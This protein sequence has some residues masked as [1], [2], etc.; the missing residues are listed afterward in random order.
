MDDDLDR[1]GGAAADATYA[2]SGALNG[3]QEAQFE[4]VSG[5]EA[6]TVRSADLGEELYRIA[7]PEG[8]PLAPSV[9]DGGD[10]VELSLNPTGRA[11]TASVEVQLNSAVR[12]RVR[13]AG[14]GLSEVVDFGAGGLAELEL[15]AGAS[16][17]DVVVPGPAGTVPIRLGAGA[18]ELI[19]HT[20]VGVPTQVRL[21]AGA[22]SVTVDGRTRTGLAA[23]TLLT[24][25]GWAE[26]TDRYDL[27]A[28]GGVANLVIDAR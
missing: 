19:I 1:G 12:W 25:A 24:P 9:T 2:V 18:G 5:A 28:T 22:A 10:R 7:T 8:G 3:R 16:K 4:L 20:P 14:G 11:G 13:L 17:I 27:E 6:V 26:A 23:G 15:V 21:D